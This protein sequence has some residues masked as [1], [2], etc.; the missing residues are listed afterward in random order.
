M[1]FVVP[2]HVLLCGTLAARADVPEALHALRAEGFQIFVAGEKAQQAAQQWQG[3]GLAVQP[4]EATFA[5][6]VQTLNP[7]IAFSGPCQANVEAGVPQR[8]V[9]SDQ[10]RACASTCWIQDARAWTIDYLAPRV[11]RRAFTAKDMP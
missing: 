5:E 7:A 3:L 9:L 11:P 2:H 8:I 4:L 10:S 6:A 1:N